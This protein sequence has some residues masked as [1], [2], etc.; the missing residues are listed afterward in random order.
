M[1]ARFEGALSGARLLDHVGDLDDPIPIFR[2]LSGDD[3]VLTRLGFRDFLQGDHGIPALFVEPHHLADARLV[4][5]DDVVAEHD[6]EALAS[7][8]VAGLQHRVAEPE[9]LLLPDVRDRHQ[10]G[11]LPDL[12]EEV[13]LAA[14]LQH[15]LELRRRVEVVFDGVLAA[16]R[17]DH[18]PLD[19]G[20]ARFLD[21]VLDE[22]PVDERQ[23]FLGLRL[24]G[25]QKPRAQAGGGEDRDAYRSHVRSVA[26]GFRSTRPG[27]DP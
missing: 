7:D 26:E 1:I 10:L 12:A 13:F 11:D 20:V 18:D 15:R 27:P 5:V 19:A 17:H 4:G 25:G 3:A 24:G 23:H 9:G 8:Q 14:L 22:R 6:R 16:P 21:D 2:A